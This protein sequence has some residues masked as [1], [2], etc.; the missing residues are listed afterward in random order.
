MVWPIIAAAVGTT[1]MMFGKNL[2]GAVAIA[3]VAAQVAALG[4]FTVID[5]GALEFYQQ[6]IVHVETGIDKGFLDVLQGQMV[7]V[8]TDGEA[9]GLQ[10]M[11][12]L[13]ALQI[14]K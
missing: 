14:G 9:V 8:I 7:D 11:Q 3:L 6:G 1:L 5:Q 13:D 12:G 2:T 10:L 4:L